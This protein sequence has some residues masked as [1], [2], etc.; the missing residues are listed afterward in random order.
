MQPGVAEAE[1]QSRHGLGIAAQAWTHRRHHP[2]VLA[3][4]Q[5]W[6]C[7]SQ[8]RVRPGKVGQIVERQRRL[9]LLL[10]DRQVSQDVYKRQSQYRLERPG[11]PVYTS[12]SGTDR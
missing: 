6:I 10:G 11:C 1:Q 3:Q 5:R 4:V 12:Q 8:Q 7:A 9:Q 2:L